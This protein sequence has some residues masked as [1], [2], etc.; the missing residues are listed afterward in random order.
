[1]PKGQTI[2][3]DVFCSFAIRNPGHYTGVDTDRTGALHTR[4]DSM[5]DPHDFMEEQ[6]F[7][8]RYLTM[9]TFLKE[10]TKALELSETIE[11]KCQLF[12]WICGE[13]VFWMLHMA[14]PPEIMQAIAGTDEWWTGFTA[15]RLRVIGMIRSEAEVE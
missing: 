4:F 7:Q 9:E 5:A 12:E 1:M 13:I 15:L 14:G 11:L 6:I 10:L 3:T 2:M 8:N